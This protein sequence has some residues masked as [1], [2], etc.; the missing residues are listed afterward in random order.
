MFMTSY[1]HFV[2]HVTKTTEQN[3]I[4]PNMY[5]TRSN[6]AKRPRDASCLS[7]ASLRHNTS[8]EVFVLGLVTSASDLLVRRPTI[9]FC[10]VVFGVTSYTRSIVIVYKFSARARLVALAL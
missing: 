5:A 4:R 3:L 6:V 2:V 7:V 9:R 8:S 10:S 1:K